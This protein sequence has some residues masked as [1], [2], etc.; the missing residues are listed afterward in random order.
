MVS[1]TVS[2]T[3]L[4]CKLSLFLCL[5][6]WTI[7]PPKLLLERRHGIENCGADYGAIVGMWGKRGNVAQKHLDMVHPNVSIESEVTINYQI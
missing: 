2:F 3:E 5:F 4:V 7:T 1:W 6:F